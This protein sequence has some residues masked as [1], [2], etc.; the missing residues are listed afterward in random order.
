MGRTSHNL[1]RPTRNDKVAGVSSGQLDRS[2]SIRGEE[3]TRNNDK[4]GKKS[5]G[6]LFVAHGP[7][8]Q[9]EMFPKNP[10]RAICPYRYPSRS[11]GAKS[12]DVTKEDAA[13]VELITAMR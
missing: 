2:R 1:E 6:H 7:L 5:E 13:A 3:R 9:Q 11:Q 12:G 4:A 10:A 8:P